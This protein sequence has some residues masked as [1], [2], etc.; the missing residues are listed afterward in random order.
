IRGREAEGLVKRSAGGPGL[1]GR[2]PFAVDGVESAGV[3]DLLRLLVSDFEEITA[4]VQPVGRAMRVA[5]PREWLN[6]DL[7]NGEQLL[8]G[9]AG[10]VVVEPHGPRRLR[11]PGERGQGEGE[12]EGAHG[13]SLLNA[14]TRGTHGPRH[15]IAR[16]RPGTSF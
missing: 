9:V 15:F 2:D 1:A 16:R 5:G 10:V 14:R 12:E 7:V 11:S 6:D 8:R 4:E 3:E 13:E